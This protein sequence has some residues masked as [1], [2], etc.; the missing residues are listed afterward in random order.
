MQDV[1]NKELHIYLSETLDLLCEEKLSITNSIDSLIVNIGSNNYYNKQCPSCKEQNID[2]RKQ[3]CPKCRARLPI[4][5][6]LPKYDTP[7]L[8]KNTTNQ[9][10]IYKPYNV[11]KE[12]KLS[13]A[14]KISITQKLSAD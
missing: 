1:M 8:K 9:S 4:L 2:N 13:T 10:T 6:E 5:A 3:F 12:T 11:E 14:P 7:E